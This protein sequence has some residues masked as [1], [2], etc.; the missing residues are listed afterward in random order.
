VSEQKQIEDSLVPIVKEEDGLRTAL[1]DIEA[2]EVNAKTKEDRRKAER[3]RWEEEQK[4]R[5]VELEKLLIKEKIE[6]LLS[7]MKGKEVLHQ[8]IIDEEAR[9]QKVLL[10]PRDNYYPDKPLRFLSFL[11]H[12]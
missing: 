10:F 6:K 11:F 1:K 7:A 8:S 5:T 9:D 3:E 4:R 2:R 12:Q